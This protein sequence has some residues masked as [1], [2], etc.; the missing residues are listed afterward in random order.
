MASTS[1]SDRPLV[2]I[3][4]VAGRY[5]LFDID[6]VMYLRRNHN[7]CSVFTGT[8]P[9][10]PQQNKFMGLPLELMPE[11]AQILVEKKVAYLADDT[12]FHPER[13][14]AWDQSTRRAY[15][16]SLRSQGKKL[17][18]DQIE[19][20]HRNRPA[21][22]PGLSN[23]KKKNKKVKEPGELSTTET[24]VRDTELDDDT[25][26]FEPPK[27]TRPP[28]PIP[29]EVEGY[30]LTPTTSKFLL[31]SP[32]SS[33]TEPLAM[34]DVP[35]SYPLFAH[36]HD[37]G[38]CMMPGLRFGCDYN[39]YPGDPLRFHSH[40]SAVHVGWEEEIP[41][42]DIVGAGRLATTVKKSYLF[43]GAVTDPSTTEDAG[44]AQVAS[45]DENE[46]S[47]PKGGPV[48]PPCRTLSLE[49]AGM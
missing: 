38:Y 49:W 40:F 26:M 15:L 33:E 19:W 37:K 14:A 35:K 44:S 8:L 22:Q 47:K 34:V 3:A 25:L 16:Q 1:S 28:K 17:Q 6:D 7:I 46:K 2:R 11:E 20:Q 42:K 10:N 32:A 39:V 43:G 48:A 30:I 29:T 23:K 13:L 36:L 4:K 18:M 24:A 9:Q 27:P 45:S 12:T 31:P 5:L 21:I 41:M